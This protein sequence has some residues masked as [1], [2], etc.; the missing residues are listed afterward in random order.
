MSAKSS[1]SGSGRKRTKPI[2]T[3]PHGGSMFEPSDLA[4]PYNSYRELSG[5]GSG[6]VLLMP[7]ICRSQTLYVSSYGSALIY[8]YEDAPRYKRVVA[9]RRFRLDS[10]PVLPTH[11][12]HTRA[13][14]NRTGAKHISCE[15]WSRGPYYDCIRRSHP[16]I[17]KGGM[18]AYRRGVTHI[19]I[20][21]FASASLGA[22]VVHAMR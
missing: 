17:R 11:A 13:M 3:G 12:T 8:T 9:I 7:Y 2:S 4:S 14:S 22:T 21:G 10:L 18:A 16:N 15:G 20:A 1:A 19:G 6:T 5:E